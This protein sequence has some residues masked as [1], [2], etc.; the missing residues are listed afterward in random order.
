MKSNKK[1]LTCKIETTYGTD[2]TPAVGTDDI[3]VS[4]FS[5]TPVNSR[6]TQRNQ[7]RPFFGAQGQIVVGETMGMEFD[8]EM[9]GAG[10]VATVPAYGP[11]LRICAMSETVTPTTGPVT[12]ATISDNEESA[13]IYF[14]WDGVRHK[15][16]GARGNC[17]WRISEGGIPYIHITLEGLY[18]GIA[19]AAL[20]GTPDLSAFQ[21]PLGVTEA[22]TT[23]SLHSYTAALASLTINRGAKNVYKNRPNSEKVHFVN[24]EVTGQVSIECPKTDVKDFFAICRAGTLGALAMTHGTSN[25]NKAILAASSVQLTNPRTSEADNMV[26]L[27]MDMI[28]LPTD[29]GNDELTYA[30]Q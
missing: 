6:Y 13:S 19:V 27:A 15:M 21:T 17:E 20:G 12:Y 2:V 18:G 4:N 3:L 26:M 14:Y 9:C 11:V 5:I 8:L 16:L 23:F 10:A 1:F 25:G 24:G 30:T 7:A 29:A 28:F 22:N